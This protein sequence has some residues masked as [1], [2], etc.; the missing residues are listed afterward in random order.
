M[1]TLLRR[2]SDLC[3]WVTK[4]MVVLLA[5]ALILCLLIAIFFRYVVGQAL[6]WPEE[7]S[8]L[9][10]A[11]LVLLASSLGVRE[12]FHVRLTVIFNRFPPLLRKEMSYSIISLIIA[13]GAV[14]FWSG[15]DLVVRTSGNLSA[16]LGY[17]L[18]IINS[19]APVC[20]VLI[21]IH[22]LYRLLAIAKGEVEL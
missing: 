13:F 17:P 9:L 11:W 22:G 7:L 12:G 18:E 10:F 3:A 8:M 16:T 19:S 6:S 4:A 1:A 21:V 14:L 2:L 15:Q 20:G 5:V